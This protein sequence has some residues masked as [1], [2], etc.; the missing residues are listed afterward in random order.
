MNI[1]KFFHRVGFAVVF[2]LGM[3]ILLYLMAVGFLL[4]LL[5][6]RTPSTVNPITV[7]LGVGGFFFVVAFVGCLLIGTPF[8]DT[9]T[10]KERS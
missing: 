7:G 8:D 10:I 6:L 2:G 1:H 3:G 5:A 4:P 9:L